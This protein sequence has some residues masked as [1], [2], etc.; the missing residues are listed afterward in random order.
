MIQSKGANL[1]GGQHGSVSYQSP[2]QLLNGQLPQ[3]GK[4]FVVTCILPLPA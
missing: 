3:V 1:A 2:E 4:I